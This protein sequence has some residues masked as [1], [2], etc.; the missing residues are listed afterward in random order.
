MVHIGQSSLHINQAPAHAAKLS[1]NLEDHFVRTVSLLERELGVEV[2]LQQG[3]GHG[4]QHPCVYGLL[5]GLALVRHR[6]R[7][8]GKDNDNDKTRAANKRHATG[9]KLNPRNRRPISVEHRRVGGTGD[10]ACHRLG[11]EACMQHAAGSKLLPKPFRMRTCDGRLP[12]P[13][14]SD[15][16][17]AD[18]R[19]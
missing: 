7:L 18:L 6:R 15:D 1:T 16:Q 5:V 17:H 12:V 11:T 4:G 13:S 8:L 10:R 14:S 3:V 19:K 2:R 9:T